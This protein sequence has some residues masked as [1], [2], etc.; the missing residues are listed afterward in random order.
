MKWPKDTRWKV[1]LETKSPT[2]MFFSSFV[3]LLITIFYRYC[4]W[5]FVR[6][7]IWRVWKIVLPIFFYYLLIFS[8]PFGAIFSLI[9]KISL[10]G[11]NQLQIMLLL[12]QECAFFN[13]TLGRPN[14]AK[15]IFIHTVGVCWA[16]IKQ[17]W[18]WSQQS[19]TKNIKQFAL[20]VCICNYHY[21]LG[22]NPNKVKWIKVWDFALSESVLTFISILG[23]NPN[24]AKY[25]FMHN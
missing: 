19:E 4:R 21:I 13:R 17:C 23:T 3:S 6:N 22:Y 24:S 15:L 16:V 8:W 5:R 12:V 2:V 11:L 20:L 7:T 1:W 14:S 10:F 18:D 9:W 25:W